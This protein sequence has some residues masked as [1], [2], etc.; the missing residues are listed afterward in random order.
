MKNMK[1]KISS[2]PNIEIVVDNQILLDQVSEIKGRIRATLAKVLHN[3]DINITLRLAEAEE[4]SRRMTKKE[5]FDELMKQ[6][7]VKSFV[8]SLGLEL[9]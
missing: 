8:E 6:K 1:P 5:V 9:T 2:F 4:I 7:E 3:G